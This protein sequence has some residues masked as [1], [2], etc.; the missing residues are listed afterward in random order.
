V[1]Q[2]TT[3]TSCG[4]LIGMKENITLHVVPVLKGFDSKAEMQNLLNLVTFDADISNE[5]LNNCIIH[6]EYH[7]GA[8][9][10]YT[11]ELLNFMRE[12]YKK[13]SLPLDHVYTGKAF[14]AMYDWILKQKDLSGQKI[15]FLHTGGLQGSDFYKSV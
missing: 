7:F 11:D 4:L 14:F 3:S 12:I 5:Y 8:Y 13:T 2:G 15:V 9:A 6:S 1:A 10:K